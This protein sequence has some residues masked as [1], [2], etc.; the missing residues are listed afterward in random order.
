MKLVGGWWEVDLLIGSSCLVRFS[1]I[2]NLISKSKLQLNSRW[3]SS[4]V[5]YTWASQKVYKRKEKK[6]A[7]ESAMPAFSLLQH[8]RRRGLGK[9]GVGLQTL[10]LSPIYP[11]HT[12]TDTHNVCVG[13]LSILVCN[14]LD[15]SSIEGH[16]QPA[17]FSS[18][19]ACRSLL[20]SLLVGNNNV[21][22]SHR[23]WV[24]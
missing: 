8:I 4:I 1:R 13:L 16:S 11:S 17:R 21:I 2:R 10:F 14:S 6:K 24:L 7:K 23:F 20:G 9:K 3:F 5:V 18:A 12:H 19:A 15:W 22:I